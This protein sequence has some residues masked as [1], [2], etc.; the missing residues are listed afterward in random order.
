MMII[1]ASERNAFASAQGDC[2]GFYRRGRFSR[3]AGY[4]SWKAVSHRSDSVY[5]GLGRHEGVSGQ[6]VSVFTAFKHILHEFGIRKIADKWENAFARQFCFC[7]IF[8]VLHADTSDNGFSE[9]RPNGAVP[10]KLHIFQ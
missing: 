5:S 9:N 1:S 3:G 2:Y 8:M 4:L 10:N 6:Q 7:T